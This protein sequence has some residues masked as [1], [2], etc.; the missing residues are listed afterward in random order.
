MLRFDSQ[1][2]LRM[3]AG[4]RLDAGM[5]FQKHTMKKILRHWLKLSR[6]A[7]VAFFRIVADN[8]AKTPPPLANPNPPL[9]DY[10][11]AVAL[12]ED[13]LA[14]VTRLEGE[15]KTARLE[16]IAAVDAAAAK[17][18][19]MARRTEDASE[20]DPALIVPVGFQIAG[21]REAT[22]DMLAPEDVNITMGDNDGELDWQL[23]P[24]DGSSGT[25]ARTSATPNDAQ[26]W[27]YHTV[28]PRSSGTIVGLP[29]GTRQ[30]VQL[31]LIGPNEPGPWSDPMSKMVP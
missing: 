12:A 27:K 2:P 8:L 10:E 28:V 11:A 19:L 16:A 30:F 6:A 25:E 21:E 23:H 13:K 3:D 1:P 15:L 14:T 17:T 5:Q 24:Q 9:V 29:S 20:G 22:G 7:R 4:V 26:S 18:E 31:R